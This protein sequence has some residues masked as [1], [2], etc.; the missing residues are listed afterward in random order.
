LIGRSRQI[1]DSPVYRVSSSIVR[2]TEKPCLDK[3]EK[4]R[5]ERKLKEDGTSQVEQA[6]R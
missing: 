4:T 6:S 1:E 3:L 5:K 2:A